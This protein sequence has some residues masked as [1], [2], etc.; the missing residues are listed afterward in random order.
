MGNDSLYATQ[1]DVWEYIPDSTSGIG[2]IENNSVFT[3][4]PNPVVDKIYINGLQQILHYE[5]RNIQG[6]IIWE[7]KDIEQQNFSFLSSGMYFLE[8]KSNTKQ[9]ILKFIKQ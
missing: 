1:S 4:Y 7:G 5:V 8:F 9:Q 3:A 6:V 2:E